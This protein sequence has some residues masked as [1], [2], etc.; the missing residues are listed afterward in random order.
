MIAASPEA[1][2]L[3]MEGSA[4]FT[5]M[6]ENGIRI[7]EPYID[8]MIVETGTKIKEMEKELR[9]DEVYRVWR[10]VYGE[11]ADLGSPTQMGRVIFGELGIESKRRTKT[12]KAAT[13]AE[14]FEDIDIPFVN[15]WVDYKKLKGV[16]TTN[17]IGI[18]RELVDGY[19]RPSFNLHLAI[20]YRSSSDRPNGQN[21]PNRDKRQA[22]IVRRAFI[23]SDD[24]HVLLE[25]DFAGIE[26]RAANCY[27][28][29]PVM[30]KYIKDD[31][32]LHKDMAAELY[33]VDRS[34]VTKD[35]RQMGKNGFVFPSFYG[36]WYLSICQALWRAVERDDLTTTDGVKVRHVLRDAGITE[37]GA[38]LKDGKPAAG[39]YAAHVKAVED[40]FWGERF[41]VYTEWKNTW[42]QQY[43]KDGYYR[44]LTG[45]VSQGIFKRNEVINGPIQGTAFH[46][47]LWTLIQLNKWLKK[48]KFK[49]R[50]ISQIHDSIKLNAYRKE[51]QD[52]LNK[53]QEIVTVD[54]P[55]HWRWINVP[56]AI[57]SSV[58]EKSWFEKQEWT[59]QSGTWKPKPKK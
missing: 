7:D 33:L 14:A 6:E 28:H 32:D 42:W 13:D 50:I 43:L 48:Y 12:G 2:K 54:L 17:L 8:R 49:S 39:T 21:I 22:K 24:E 30:T 58:C 27:H 5:D 55:N 36:D 25:A 1:Y 35:M 46:W 23:P 20:T 19:L 29:D 41:K 38:S 59:L 10:K 51:L 18:K 37:L 56:L 53:I 45:F 3:L 26:V 9:N 11:K 31:Y 52:V 34:R 47:L 16:R 4:T 40:R 15:R 57:E 44:L